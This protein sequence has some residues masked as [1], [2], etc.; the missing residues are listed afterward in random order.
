MLMRG[1][2]IALGVV[3]GVCRRL[4]G[5]M[6][7]RDGGGVFIVALDCKV[8]R[9]AVFCVLVILRSDSGCMLGI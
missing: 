4:L 8:T 7:V 9:G 1:L 5:H 3:D 2:V 6:D